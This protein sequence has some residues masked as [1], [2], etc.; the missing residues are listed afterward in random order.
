MHLNSDII[1]NLRILSK[2]YKKNE[3]VWRY[4]AYD[5]AITS[6]K[7]LDFKVTDIEQV[8]NLKGV[9][10]TIG[11]K[12]KEY[13]HTG[14]IRKVEEVQMCL[15]QQPYKNEKDIIIDSFQSIWGVGPVK[16]TEL[17][18]AGFRSIKQ[19]RK[20]QELLTTQQRI[21]LKYY[22]DLLK[23]LHREYIDTIGSTIRHVLNKKFGKDMYKLEIA[24][25]YRRGCSTSG[26]VDIIV[27]SEHFTLK[28][29]VKALTKTNIITDTLS[30]KEEKFMGIS[31]CSNHGFFR[32]DIEFLP[33]E[34][35]GSGILYFTGSKEFN[36][37]MRYIAKKQ[38]LIL[39][40]HGLFKD[41][42]RLPVF[43]EKEIFRELGMKY[44]KPSQ[45]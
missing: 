39:N 13:L 41:K 2:H 1:D 3:D 33:K 32:L 17:W 12:I 6:I 18:K 38:G 22:K 8:K 30:M 45:R 9:G 16:A 25:S 10:K 20:N 44:I 27:S 28:R 14:E 35:F 31:Q 26:D 29:M 15:L 19:L 34:E 36:I 7:G 37:N 11:D 21:G 5:R 40:Q 43:T 42:V 4:R 24:G 23:S